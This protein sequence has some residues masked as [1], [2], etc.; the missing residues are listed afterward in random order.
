MSKTTIPAGG[1]ATDSVTTAKIADDA[2]T[3]AKATG[4]GK[5]GQV[6]ETRVGDQGSHIVTTS[7]SL[8]DSGISRTITPSASSSKIIVRFLHQVLLQAKY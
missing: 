1:L 4:F 5:I 6:I 7:T 2:V 8:T 3:A